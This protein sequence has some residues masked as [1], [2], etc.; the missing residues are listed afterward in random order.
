MYGPYSN[1]RAKPC[2]PAHALLLAYE[3]ADEAAAIRYLDLRHQRPGRHTKATCLVES[4]QYFCQ[5][6]KRH[7]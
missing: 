6:F 4:H 7:A 1:K 5:R 2:G 3:D